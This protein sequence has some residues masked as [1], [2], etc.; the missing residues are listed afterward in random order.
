MTNDNDISE[1]W[2]MFHV[3]SYLCDTYIVT[4]EEATFI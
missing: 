1:S 2:D 3:S 4:K